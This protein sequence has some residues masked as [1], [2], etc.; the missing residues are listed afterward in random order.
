MLLTD[1]LAK[2]IIRRITKDRHVCGFSDE[3]LGHILTQARSKFETEAATLVLSSPII[4]FG[5]I[6]G[7]LTDLLK[8]FSIV[9]PPPK[10]TLLFLGDYV[11]RGKQSLEVIT[12]LFCYKILYPTFIYLVRGN[13]ECSRMNSIYGFHEELIR[14]RSTTLWKKF[15][16]VF[17]QL[18]LCATI[19]RKILCMHG[20]ISPNIT[21]WDSLLSLQK[22][23][24]PS[25]CDEGLAL[26]LMWSDPTSDA[27]CPNYQFNQNRYTSVMFGKMAVKKLCELLQLNLI[28]RAHEVVPNGHLWDFDRHIV[29]LFSA[30][31][32]CGTDGNAG[33]IMTVSTD[34]TI[35][36]LSLKPTQPTRNLTE[37]E[38]T[39]LKEKMKEKDVVSP[40]PLAQQQM[41]H[42]N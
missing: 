33:S 6:H 22:P 1:V 16:S 36:F 39:K 13:H 20:G 32:Y 2:R 41:L 26:D 35:S 3:E 28:V 15:N 29:T 7:Q 21:C 10:N 34:Y 42:K 31:N 4:I 40:D 5:D 17:D 8:F 30:P 27:C 14:K 11:D 9:G 37:E 19:G 25:E 12:L 18:P 23:R 24:G 38:Q